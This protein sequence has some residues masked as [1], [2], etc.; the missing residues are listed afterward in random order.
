[1]AVLNELIVWQLAMALGQEV[2][3]LAALPAARRDF[4]MCDQL[5]RASA[6]ISNNLAEGYGRNAPKEFA[7]F[8]DIASGSLRE[9]ETILRRHVGASWSAADAEPA[10]TGFTC[11]SL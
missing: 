4:E 10:I 7:R 5:R 8:L 2:E 1:M 3:R 11:T 9:T 6:S